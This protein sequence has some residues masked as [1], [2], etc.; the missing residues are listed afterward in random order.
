MR[1]SFLIMRVYSFG[2]CSLLYYSSSLICTK[3]HWKIYEKQLF[4][5][6]AREVVNERRTPSACSDSALR[7]IATVSEDELQ[8]RVE[9][10]VVLIRWTL[11]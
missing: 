2:P 6:I 3:L 7:G 1:H 5:L 11:A 8:S 4:N 10:P 9:K